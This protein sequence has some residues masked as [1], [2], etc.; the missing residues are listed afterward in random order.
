MKHNGIIKNISYTVTSNLVSFIISA[1]VTFFVPKSLG[2]ENYGYFQLYIFYTSYT[3]LLYLGWGD[4]VYLKYGGAYYDK[5]DKR[6]ISGQFWGI[7]VYE[8]IVF[9]ALLFIGCYFIT[10]ESK[11]SVVICTGAYIVVVWPKTILLFILQ[12]TN[13]IR[14]YSIV[15]IIEKVVYIALVI[16]ALSL[17]VHEFAPIIYADLVGK[18]A[19]LLL[20]IWYCKDIV[21]SKPYKIKAILNDIHEDISIGIKLTLSNISSMLIIGIVR[22]S[23]ERQWSIAEFGKVSLSLSIS[24]MLMVFVNAVALV[25][26]P[27]LRRTNPDRYKDIYETL[28]NLLMILLLG[29]LIVYYPMRAVLN[30]WLPQYADS[31]HYMAILFPLCVFESKNSMLITTYLKTLRKEQTLMM[32]NIVAMIMSLLVSGITVFAMKNLEVAILSII[33]LIGFRCVLAELIVSRILDIVVIKDIVYELIA[34]TIFIVSSWLIGGIKGMLLYSVVY[35]VYVF[36]KRDSLK[37]IIGYFIDIK[38]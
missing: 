26:F 21:R 35:I 38:R 6:S 9:V 7:V 3:G 17:N 22:Y 18:T 20:S 13:R 12:C 5:L 2:V 30:V 31:L 24:N 15:V 1:V 11:A 14:E 36:I 10:P 23:I 33:V 16:I 29:I 32:I 25:M 34:V 28:R 27:V 4:G 37:T 8:M 19:A